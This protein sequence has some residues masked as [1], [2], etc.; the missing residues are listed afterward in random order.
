ME[1]QP[2]Y[3]FGDFSLDPVERRLARAGHPVALTARQFEA[4]LLFVTRAGELLD[5]DTLIAELW[6][7]LVV[8]E[9]NLNQVIS[10]LRRALGDES[11]ES[12]YVQTV[13][14]RGY[15]FVARVSV[16][17]VPDAE[18]AR[19][20]VPPSELKAVDLS[21]GRRAFVRIGMTWWAAAGVLSVGAGVLGW[22]AFEARRTPTLARQPLTLAVL[23]FKPLIS[24]GRDELLEIGMADSLIARLSTV[25]GLVVRSVGSVR[26]YSGLEQDPLAAARELDVVWI[27]D[28]S[29]QRWGDQVRVTAR[30]LRATDGV[31]LWSGSFE[32]RF[33]NVF[34][35]QNTISERVAQVFSPR[36][37][38][39]DRLG[40]AGAGGTRNA[41]AYQLYLAARMH[42]QGLRADGLRRSVA[43]YGKAVE[44]D[45]NYA[46]AY[47]GTV[48]TY[49]RMI[50]GADAE[51]EKAFEP[52]KLAARRAME[53]DPLLAEAHAGPG[54]ISFWYDWD[55]TVAEAKFRRAIELNPNVVDAH[56]GLGLL[57]LTLD[58]GDEGLAHLQTARELDPA[59]LL[60]NTLEAGFLFAR[61]QREGG[62]ARLQRVLEIQ[63]EFWIAYLTRA[64][65]F[66]IDLQ[67]ERAIEVLQR[68]DQLTD[69]ST[70]AAGLLGQVLAQQGRRDEALAILARLHTL[71]RTRYVPPTS[72]AMVYSGLGEVA[73]ALSEL[74]RAFEV[75]DT[76]LIYLKD[77]Q[78]WAALRV[79]PRYVA[80]L[81][82]MKLDRYGSGVSAI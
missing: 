56:F 65:F 47:T 71:Q 55:W 60:L 16:P 59:S 64:R 78:R 23:P 22:R 11:H 19:P 34:D 8:E 75:R 20:E 66:L 73:S 72:I 42:A 17:T 41:D 68:A 46:L 81:G 39:Q 32:E 70:Q 7:G 61:G 4:L 35:V 1:A 50:F 6:P 5:K 69:G 13:P 48:E 33:T 15:R 40:L 57:L 12:R 2:R 9:N 82:K 67:P 51:P 10:G 62:A 3:A 79:Q 54:W 53:I 76:R 43:L 74:E 24:E 26:R 21:E 29:V 30:L 28:G 52:A 80:L 77:D 49:R 37:A 14:R 58:R 44:F 27:V 25:P 18:Q 63:P 38:Q 45:P 36:L 31:A